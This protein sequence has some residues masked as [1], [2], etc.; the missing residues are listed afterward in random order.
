[1]ISFELLCSH[2]VQRAGGRVSIR[3]DSG[4]CQTLA[5]QVGSRSPVCLCQHASMAKTC[6]FG[7]CCRVAPPM[8]ATPPHVVHPGSDEPSVRLILTS[9]MFAA[10]VSCTTLNETSPPSY[11]VY[12]EVTS[13]HLVRAWRAYQVDIHILLLLF[14]HCL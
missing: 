4:A 10:A 7:C 8:A 9:C 14:I 11:A 2:A 13:V 5:P 3:H 6:C 1:M 12:L